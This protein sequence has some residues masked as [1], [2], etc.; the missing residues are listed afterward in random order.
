[1]DLSEDHSFHPLPTNTQGPCTILQGCTVLL[2]LLMSSEHCC[3]SEE[4]YTLGDRGYNV[5]K[6]RTEGEHVV[7]NPPQEEPEQ[8]GQALPGAA[9]NF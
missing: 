5:R 3:L 1:M 6:R 2:P 8:L 9:R 7:G 4:N